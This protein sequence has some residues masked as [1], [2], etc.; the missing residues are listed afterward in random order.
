MRVSWL[1]VT[2]TDWCVGYLVLMEN[3]IQVE[4]L[5]VQLPSFDCLL[6]LYATIS[7]TCVYFLFI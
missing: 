6:K 5:C 4:L 7:R 2:V 1:I 3:E